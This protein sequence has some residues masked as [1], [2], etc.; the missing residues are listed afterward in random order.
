MGPKH[1]FLS[2][3]SSGPT[4][5][6]EALVDNTFNRC[7]KENVHTNKIGKHKNRRVL[8]RNRNKGESENNLKLVG[9]NAAGLTSKLDSFD[10]L[11]AD[12]KPGVFFILETKIR[13]EGRIK[14]ENT[15]NYQIYEKLRKSGGGGGVALGVHHD[16]NP[17]WV[18]DGPG[19]IE[20]LSVEITVE[21]LKIR[22]VAAY[23]PQETGPSME[24]K[25]K[26][27]EHLP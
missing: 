15:K 23:G 24:D 19:E 10:K 27:W 16:L 14:T 4:E 1:T 26:F 12:I 13:K 18:G 7:G 6:V 17:A 25:L 11:L 3:I 2:G 9:V 5:C 22:C 8:N 20:S 21:K